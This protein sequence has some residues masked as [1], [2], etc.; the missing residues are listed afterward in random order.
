MRI[1]IPSLVLLMSAT[2]ALAEI[3]AIEDVRR[4]EPVTIAGT[5]ERFHDEDEIRVRDE[6]GS[7]RVYLGPQ[8]IALELGQR[9]QISGFMDGDLILNELYAREIVTED[10]TVITV[11]RGYE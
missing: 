10:G 4:N 11:E 5:I 2:P 1:A 9:I 3:T 7:I 8:P 6:T